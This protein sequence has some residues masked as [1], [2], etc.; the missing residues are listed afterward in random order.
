MQISKG[1]IANANADCKW[2]LG[3]FTASVCISDCDVASKW[4]PFIPMVLFTLSAAKHQR[5]SRERKLNR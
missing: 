3:L 2:Y 1:N 5:K 4:V